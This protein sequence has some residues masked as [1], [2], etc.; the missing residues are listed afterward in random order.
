MSIGEV[1]RITSANM[2]VEFQ[3]A[4]HPLYRAGSYA[5]YDEEQNHVVVLALNGAASGTFRL[6]VN[7]YRTAPITASAT[8][9]ATAV[10][11]ALEALPN[12]GTGDLTV[13]GSAGG[14]FTIT[15][16]AALENEFLIIDVVDK[17]GAASAVSISVTSQGSKWYRLDAEMSGLSYSSTI[18]TVDVT[19]MS[20]KARRHSSTVSDATFDL[21][22]Y[23][24]LREYRFML[25]AG[26]EG[27]LRVFEDGKEIN[28]RYFAWQTMFSD[29]ATDFKAFDKVEISISGR[30]QGVDI[31]PVG[32][33]WAG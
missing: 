4:L 28:K 10:Q 6:V 19:G 7:G 29:D 25:V 33:R 17:T 16:A 21:T 32:S 1:T 24:A 22:L 15:A 5:G 3:P 14:A 20:E 13:T 26:V 8:L 2:V 9:A 30:R 31:A 27:Y 11:S 18:D 23:E 12:V